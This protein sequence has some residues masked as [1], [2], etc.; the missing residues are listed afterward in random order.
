M[1]SVKKSTYDF[2]NVKTRKKKLSKKVLDKGY[3]ILHI[4]K[5]VANEI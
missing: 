2:Y 4:Y 1:V 5:L 3:Q